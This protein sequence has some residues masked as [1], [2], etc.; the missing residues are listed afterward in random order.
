MRPD[1]PPLRRALP[2]AALLALPACGDDAAATSDAAT[3]AGDTSAGDTDA[4]TDTD[5]GGPAVDLLPAPQHLIRVSMALRGMRPSEAELAAVEADPAALPAIVDAY[6]AAPELGA[7]VR[8]V[9]NDALLALV[10]FAV[11]PAGF[12]PK[13][14]LAGA[15][16]YALNRAVM[17]APLRLVERV[18]MDDRPFTE[19]VT[20]DYTLADPHVAAVWGLAHSG[21][22]GWEETQWTG[23]RAR[24]GLLSDSWLWSRHSSTVTNANRGRASAMARAFLCHD[25]L[26]REIAIDTDVNLADPNV[27]AAAVEANPSCAACHQALDPLA[28]FFSGYLPNFAPAILDYPIQT[29]VPG[30]FDK[31]FKVNLRPPSYYGAPGDD[32]ADLGA[33]IAADPRFSL[34]AARRFYAYVHQLSPEEVPQVRAAELQRTLLD[35]GMKIRPLLREIV[36]ADDFRRRDA[37]PRRARPLHLARLIEDLTGFRWRTDLSAFGVGKVDLMDDTLIGFQVLGGGI[38]AYY[39]TRPSHAFNATASLVLQGLARVAANAVVERDLA[40]PDPSK[41]A[42]LTKVTTGQTDEPSVRAQLV[43]LF[44]RLYGVALAA[45]DPQITA[46]HRLFADTLAAAPL[47]NPKVAWKITLTA[48][49]QDHRI[50]FY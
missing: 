11:P 29:W 30:L 26:D 18:V 49:L 16:P 35:G 48:L 36:L 43:A 12:L 24:A 22:P 2:L 21:A 50:A 42:L 28:S 47:K 32:L 38:D 3:T 9:Y 41:R 20:A 45:D 13:G 15:D 40:E 25:F 6:L 31:L 27:V 4:G 44:R 7:T 19:I 10:D 37:G 34:C 1:L 46:A 17:E 33:M 8:D 39:V 5:T 14:Q 23:A